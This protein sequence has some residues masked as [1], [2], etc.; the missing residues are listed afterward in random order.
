MI[1]VQSV[2]KRWTMSPAGEGDLGLCSHLKFLT[3][4]KIKGK[5]KVLLD[6]KG[7]CKK[8]CSKGL[9]QK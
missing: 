9:F 3:R 8:V 1:R 4:I 7:F 5:K 2:R 6:E